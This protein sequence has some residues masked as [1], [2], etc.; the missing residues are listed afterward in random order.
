LK[1]IW[2][3]ILCGYSLFGFA[4]SCEIP[5]GINE[6][7]PVVKVG[8]SGAN[9]FDSGNCATIVF[10]LKEK[11]KQGDKGLIP[12]N[13]E[14][15]SSNNKKFAKKAKKATKKW[16]FLSKNTELNTKYYS[17]LRAR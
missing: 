1:I 2:F 12:T 10:E 9:K 15:F 7:K 17:I 6:A 11:S 3:I 16:L 8:V 14:I 13:I 4:E 5:K